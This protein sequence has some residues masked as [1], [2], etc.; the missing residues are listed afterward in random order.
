MGLE[1][2]TQIGD[3]V[4]ANPPGTDPKSQ[5]DDHL[6]LL[7]TCVQGSLGLMAEFWTIPAAVTGLRQRNETD[8][9]TVSL[10]TVA[11][12]G[13]ISIGD[14]S[15]QVNVQGP[16][17]TAGTILSGQQLTVVAGG[18]N[19]TGTITNAGGIV[20][21]S[22]GLT[23]AGLVTVQAGGL[24][25]DQDDFTIVG[26][27]NAILTGGGY[28]STAPNNAAVFSMK[29]NRSGTNA[30]N[31]F[32]AENENAS[33]TYRA[34]AT[35]EH[36]D[37]GDIGLGNSSVSV[38]DFVI[39]QRSLRLDSMPSSPAGLGSGELWRSGNIVNIV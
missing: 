25:L 4:P 11:A 30:S 34:L 10:I 28:A 22:A 5:G 1:V 38:N 13:T 27:G 17:T 36:R 39:T 12:N 24:T 7:K 9:G 19:I 18:A 20:I 2:G 23:S 15:R 14:D 16:L 37:N 3:L 21:T 33:A 35:L 32:Q 26:V 6:R 29:A 8:D 31:M